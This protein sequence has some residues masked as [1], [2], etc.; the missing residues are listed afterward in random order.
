MARKDESSQILNNVIEE[1]GYEQKRARELE[2]L[3]RIDLRKI[4][5][6]AHECAGKDKEVE[7]NA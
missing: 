5:T 2:L 3:K 6:D 1:Q 4:F 7:F